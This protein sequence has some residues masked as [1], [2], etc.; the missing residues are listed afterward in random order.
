[1][2][3]IFFLAAILGGMTLMS[4]AQARPARCLVTVEKRV[5]LN[6]MC[7]FRPEG[8]DGSFSLGSLDPKG[9]L[10]PDLGSLSLSVTRPGLAQVFVVDDRASQWGPARRSKIDRACWVGHNGDFKICVY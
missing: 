10:A 7:D 2:K 3:A 5:L 1:M 8:K 9:K 6:H 4:P